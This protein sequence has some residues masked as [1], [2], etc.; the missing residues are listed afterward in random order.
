MIVIATILYVIVKII[1]NRY[2]FNVIYKYLL[3]F[4]VFALIAILI[5]SVTF[6]P[7]LMQMFFDNR[8]GQAFGTVILYPLKYYETL[9]SSFTTYYS[10]Q[11]R[12]LSYSAII[13]IS[14]IVI[15]LNR[16]RMF[17]KTLIV[18]SLLFICIPFF[19]KIFNGGG[20]V[21]NR[22]SF[23]L[24]LLFSYCITNVYE[25][26]LCINSQKK[27]IL[28]VVLAI[29]FL[30]CNFI[31]YG[32][33]GFFYYQ[34]II[35]FLILASICF[36][37]YKNTL[38]AVIVFLIMIS[39]IINSYNYNINYG[40]V[41][42]AFTYNK[43]KESIYENESNALE[44]YKNKINDNEYSRYVSDTPYM[45]KGFRINSFYHYSNNNGMLT[46]QS[47]VEYYGS[48]V[49]PYAD[50]YNRFIGNTNYASHWW[51]TYCDN[52]S[53]LNALSSVKYCVYKEKDSDVVLD[54]DISTNVDLEVDSNIVYNF[55]EDFSGNEDEDVDIE[56]ENDL[57]SLENIDTHNEILFGYKY[58]DNINGYKIYKNNNYV[59]IFYTY[60]NIIDKNVASNFNPV[61]RHELM[62]KNAIID[63]YDKYNG[64]INTKDLTK[65][66]KNIQYFI[67]NDSDD[68]I[69]N[70]KSIITSKKNQEITLFFN[71]IENSENYIYIKGLYYKS[72]P[73]YYF[74]YNKEIDFKNNKYN[75]DS[76]NKFAKV[77]TKRK[78]KRLLNN[79]KY[80]GYGQDVYSLE[81]ETSSGN[82]KQ[83][84]QLTEYEQ[85]YSDN[86][87]FAINMG[88]Y[89]EKLNFIKIKF[90]NVGIYTFD[91]ISVICQ[92]LKY[93][94]D[95]IANLKSEK[96]INTSVYNDEIST[97]VNLSENKFICLAIPYHYGWKAY[98]DGKET[99]IYRTNIMHMGI[100]ANE[101]QHSIVFR[102]SN[103][104]IKIGFL[105]SIFGTIILLLY[106]VY[107][108]KI[109][110]FSLLGKNN[111]RKS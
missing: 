104:F 54:E 14:V 25:E 5:S 28:Y 11:W 111:E 78:S 74:Y 3:S 49:N 102:Y 80:F 53:A 73:E 39:I 33:G 17:L 8:K 77:F 75:I 83:L 100:D 107:D 32:H 95:S 47:P 41:D 46:N 103:P 61:E 72:L 67:E 12:I 76:S 69:V 18:I 40:T 106:I 13:Y 50:E 105:L 26:M 101:G 59:P 21:T 2:N 30:L 62:T 79:K 48:I 16:G 42:M 10:I 92:P 22:F 94:K 29:L 110:K 86:H 82:E 85:S 97:Q 63:S 44:K 84:L 38:Q 15:F 58:L 70:E 4:F 64:N 31:S 1:I 19:G 89:N 51:E 90:P 27:I 45:K 98:L 93:L 99:K 7:K 109:L 66:S 57:D 37:M 23:M 52:S 65:T 71:G 91:E 68:I 55:F 81:F 43:I 87:N 108:K 34:I 9:I 96:F 24:A 56:L 35:T 60:N 20:Y 36:P 6:L 88:Y